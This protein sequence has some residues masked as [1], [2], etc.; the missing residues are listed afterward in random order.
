MD[1]Y[2]ETDY[3]EEMPDPWVVRL[4]SPVLFSPEVANYAKLFKSHNGVGSVASSRR[5]VSRCGK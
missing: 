3:P 5:G 2:M 1:C 4:V